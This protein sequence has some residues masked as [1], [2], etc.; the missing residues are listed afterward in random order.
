[1]IT[2]LSRFRQFSEWAPIAIGTWRFAL[3]LRGYPFYGYLYP[4]MADILAVQIGTWLW[5]ILQGVA[6]WWISSFLI[7]RTT[8]FVRGLPEA[9]REPFRLSLWITL[10]TAAFGLIARTMIGRGSHSARPGMFFWLFYRHEAPFLFA[11][12]LFAV[13]ALFL[14]RARET[15]SAVH[16]FRAPSWLPILLAF[17]VAILCRIGSRYAMHD[18]DF[19]ADE[20]AESFQ[21]RIFASGHVTSPVPPDWQSLA[22]ALTPTFVD[23][24]PRTHSWIAGFLPIFSLIRALFVVGHVARWTNPAL[25]GLAILLIA[26]IAHRLWPEDGSTRIVAILFLALSSQFLVASMSGYA[27]PAGLTFNLL[28]L[29]LYLEERTWARLLFPLVGAIALGVH[30]PLDHALFVAPFLFLVVRSARRRWIAYTAAVYLS[31]CWAWWV[32]LGMTRT[33]AGRQTGSLFVAPGSAALF[34]QGLS[35]T[36]LATW[37]TP[38][39]FALLIA[40]FIAWRRWTPVFRCLLAGI[41]LNA[42][43]FLLVVFD[44]GHGW[45][46][47]YAHGIIGNVALIAALVFRELR[48]NHPAVFTRLVTVSLL[49]TIGLQLPMRWRQAESSIRP[50]Y[51]AERVIRSLPADV[52]GI[53][54]AMNWYAGDLVRNDPFLRRGPKIVNLQKVSLSERADLRARFADRFRVFTP[55]ELDQVGLPLAPL[56]R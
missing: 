1:M 32:W 21:S 26:R 12:G 36:L 48:K 22:K 33:D 53:S 4:P 39:A 34:R 9:A 49:L 29:A 42:A 27:M 30:Y 13:F 11:L 50:F 14:I 35:V 20:F 2:F 3:A 31:G 43:F 52:V 17:V 8:A 40:G 51:L 55:E 16:E 54:P 23:Y 37:Q 28:W 38:V 19:A 7:R 47:R 18:Y 10:F 24:L 44:Q 25:A 45:G 6:V 46:D 5:L 15:H 56:R 41:A